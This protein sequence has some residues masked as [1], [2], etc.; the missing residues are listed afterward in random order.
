M[1]ISP[2]NPASLPTISERCETTQVPIEL[3]KFEILLQ[4]LQIAQGSTE[5]EKAL[6]TELL[7]KT[8]ALA[9]LI[10]EG[11]DSENSSS[12]AESS[13]PSTPKKVERAVTRIL[14]P[15]PLLDL[16]N[17]KKA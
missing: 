11:S 17:F 6:C 8:H 1:K 13:P 12:S 7:S 2:T 10:Q 9:I 15:L 14:S 3:E 16:N 4:R 5:R